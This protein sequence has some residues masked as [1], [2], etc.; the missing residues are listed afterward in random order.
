VTAEP[1][2]KG[3][4][5]NQ[6][7]DKVVVFA[8]MV[9]AAAAASGN[10]QYEVSVRSLYYQ[11]RPRIEQYRAERGAPAKELA[12]NYFSQ[13]LVPDYRREVGDIVGL[14][15]DPRGLLVEPHSDIEV[16][17]GTREVAGYRLP[18]WTFD[19]V[20]YIEKRGVR[21]IIASARFAERYDMAVIYGEGFAAEATRDLLALCHARNITIFTLHDAD[22]HGYD[23]V[24]CLENETRRMPD[25]NIEVIDL[26]LSVADAIAAGLPVESATYDKAIDGELLAGLDETEREWLAGEQVRSGRRSHWHCQRVEL[27]AFTA[28]DLVAFV[29]RRLEEV[30]AD[31]KLMPPEPV[32]RELAEW[33]ATDSLRD[34]VREWI[35][36]RFDED[37]LTVALLERFLESIL[38]ATDL[39][40]WVSDGYAEDRGRSWRG[41]VARHVVRAVNELGDSIEEY[42]DDTDE[43]E[44]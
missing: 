25:H 42:L 14:Y 20:L 24:R 2:R 17:L 35:A 18:Q 13:Y 33:Y 26:G 11:V 31:R 44:R 8:V 10:G 21:P 39:A 27:N 38:P 32:L 9:E 28:P 7:T 6:L 4:W 34:A 29:E 5:K 36:A 23:I 1:A 3:R 16:P 19:K 43:D 40:P 41:I 22:R 15:Y 12:Y 37:A 30:G